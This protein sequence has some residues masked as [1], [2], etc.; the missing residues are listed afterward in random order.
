M[1]LDIETITADGVKS[2]GKLPKD[3]MGL[4]DLT[5]TILVDKLNY[6][7]NEA[8]VQV[9]NLKDMQKL[10]EFLNQYLRE[11][12]A[13]TKDSDGTFDREPMEALVKKAKKLV[14]EFEQCRAEAERIKETDPKKAEWL[15]EY[16]SHIEDTL[17]SCDVINN[18][19]ELVKKLKYSETERDR[20]VENLRTQNKNLTQAIN[21]MQQVVQKFNNIRHE[22]L[23]IA[24][25]IIEN[26]NST[27]RKIISNHGG[28]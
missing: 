19:G 9:E 8:R 1:A 22:S 21:Y 13:N 14:K 20:L 15:N 16:A 25:Q 28:R 10:L 6:A 17:K 11:V 26:L 2:V 4:Q 27:F 24:K 12:N 3:E 23:M 7:E 5:H 18:K